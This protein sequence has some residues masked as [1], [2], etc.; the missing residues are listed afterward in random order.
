MND[1]G[2]KPPLQNPLRVGLV[3]A[4]LA[5]LILSCRIV[6]PNQVEVVEGQVELIIP[7][8]EDAGGYNLSPDGRWMLFWKHTPERRMALLDLTT[9]TERT[10]NPAPCQGITAVQWLDGHRFF[11]RD[12]PDCYLLV[13]T[14][15]LSILRLAN[16]SAEEQD[17]VQ[18][19]QG[20]T[21]ADQVYAVLGMGSP[22]HSVSALGHEPPTVYRF[23]GGY[24]PD[25]ERA[26]LAAI[27]GV[28]F[29]EPPIVDSTHKFY[30]H[31]GR[32]YADTRGG[33]A[34]IYSAE[35]EVLAEAH[36]PGWTPGVVGW[37]ADDS[38]VYLYIRIKGSSAQVETPQTP[39]FKLSPAE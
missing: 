11:L 8:G 1:Q 13:K 38:G 5:G 14:D 30:S 24:F 6:H 28:V 4:L 32:L 12:W 36:K 29:L 17:V 39:L 20:L 10:V 35:G 19:I 37:A 3:C 31:D 21:Q 34:R 25:E 18:A 23:R 16:Y 26:I 7:A 9:G 22:S 15:D 2:L 33:R 27:P